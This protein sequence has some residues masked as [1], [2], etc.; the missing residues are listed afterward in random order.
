MN[1]A[2]LAAEIQDF[3]DASLNE[4]VLKL[5]FKKN[6]FKEVDYKQIIAQIVAKKKAKT[7]LPTWFGTKNILYPSKISIEQTS[8]EITA[9]YKASLVSGD[10]L[11]DLTGGF[12]VDD[13]YFSK[14]IP[15]VTHCEIDSELSQTVAH[16]FV[17]L[18]ARNIKCISGDST[19]ILKNSN[20]SFS[21]IYIDPSRRNETKGKVFLLKDCLPDITELQ[22]FYYLFS[23][24][25]LIKTAPILDI[26]AGL[27]ELKNVKTIHIVAVDNEVKELLWEIEKGFE[28][29][30]LIKTLNICKDNTETFDFQLNSKATTAFSLPKKYLYEPNSAIMKSGGYNEIGAPF[31]VEKLHPN[32]HLYTSEV[33][34][35]FPG[36]VFKIE[37]EIDYSK[38]EMSQ[39]LEGQ[40]VNI[41]TRNFPETVE[42]IRQR[43]KIKEG[44]TLYCF[45]T[46]NINE[47]KIVLLCTKINN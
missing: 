35:S 3:I 11:I 25:I 26:S 10:N 44:G 22:D 20:T 40:K 45:F 16:N 34:C 18:K 17:V 5:S 2:L 29:N 7:K 13:Y 30:S 19:E 47:K 27:S 12:G 41:T 38:K 6:P 43:W 9:Q 24:H 23:N 42:K 28:G 39:N 1:S 37:K 32:S 46:T 4:D 31:L 14:V 36:R 15:Q 8:S 21:W 33:L